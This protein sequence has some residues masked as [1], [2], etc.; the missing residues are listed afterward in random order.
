MPPP[1][2]MVTTTCLALR[3]RPSMSACITMRAPERPYG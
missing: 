1:M 3:L 2:H